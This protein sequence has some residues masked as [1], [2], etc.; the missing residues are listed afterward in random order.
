MVGDL[1]QQT[2]PSLPSGPLAL[3]ASYVP[4]EDLGNFML[5]C[6]EFRDLGRENVRHLLPRISDQK[7]TDS[8]LERLIYIFPN[9]LSIYFHG[10]KL[11]SPDLDQLTNQRDLTH[12]NFSNNFDFSGIPGGFKDIV[13]LK[14]LDLS[15]CVRMKDEALV[16]LES[17]NGLTHLNLKLCE[18]LTDNVL[19]SIGALTSLQSLNLYGCCRIRNYEEML[20]TMAGLTQLIYL[21]FDYFAIE[22]EYLEAL[23]DSLPHLLNGDFVPHRDDS[24][25]YGSE[26]GDGYEYA[27]SKLL[28]FKGSEDSNEHY[29][30]D[31][32]DYF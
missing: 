32:D 22:N 21:D 23:K 15:G 13:Q 28:E 29:F 3:I 10:G 4:H 27:L 17:L 16:G 25:D 18:G 19:P 1:D 24:D 9:L 11:V 12:I 31:S 5:V 8:Q 7:I 2:V 14:S 20:D 30:D 26:Y 6:K